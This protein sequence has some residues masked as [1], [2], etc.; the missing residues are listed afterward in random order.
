M[1]DSG[2]TTNGVYPKDSELSGL[3]ANCGR[4]W[5]MAPSRTSFSIFLAL[6][7]GSLSPSVDQRWSDLRQSLSGLFC[8]TLSSLDASRTS[9]PISIFPS[10]PLPAST[11]ASSSYHLRHGIL[12]GEGVCTENLTPFA[13]LLPCAR[14]SGLGS[15]LEPHR[16]F[17]ADWHGMGVHVTWDPALGVRVKMTFGA[18]FNPV[19]TSGDGRRGETKHLP[20]EC[21][22]L[23]AGRT[24]WSLT[25]LFGRGVE[26]SC[27]AAASSVVKVL[28]AANSTI[29]PPFSS[30]SSD[31]YASYDL[32]T[33]RNMFLSLCQHSLMAL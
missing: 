16:L 9:S 2:T 32:V 17:D 7:G 19:R 33:G 8:A 23:M 27:P 18:V 21:K 12:P 6:R 5:P 11:N 10:G 24:D 30:V 1:L 15:L 13:A 14:K 28:L 29:V 22:T 3:E 4:G 31:G 20:D 26:R 25:T